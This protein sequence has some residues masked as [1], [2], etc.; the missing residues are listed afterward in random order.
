[1]SHRIAYVPPWNHPSFRFLP[2]MVRLPTKGRKR[3]ATIWPTMRH[4]DLR[5]GVVYFPLKTTMRRRRPTIERPIQLRILPAT[6]GIYRRGSTVEINVGMLCL[7]S[8]KGRPIRLIFD[9]KTMTPSRRRM[10]T[11]FQPPGVFPLLYMTT[12]HL[13]CRRIELVVIAGP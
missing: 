4:P 8:T 1:M 7:A 9:R 6:K 12:R 11:K 10:T 5:G 13:H 3:R 2:P